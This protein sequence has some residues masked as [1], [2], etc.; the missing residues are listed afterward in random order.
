M[1]KKLT[2][3]KVLGWIIIVFAL[4]EVITYLTFFYSGISLGYIPIFL[5]YYADVSAYFLNLYLR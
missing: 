4:N 1:T 5:K 2:G 3:I